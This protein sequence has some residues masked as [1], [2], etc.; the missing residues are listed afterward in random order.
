MA[1]LPAALARHPLH[2]HGTPC[3]RAAPPAIQSPS[4]Q[5]KPLP[6]FFRASL[7]EFSTSDLS[8]PPLSPHYQPTL[9]LNCHQASPS[10][11]L[12]LALITAP[13]YWSLTTQCIQQV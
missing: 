5:P 11:K 9:N 7:A 1:K 6:A 10:H 3:T 2:S 13:L 8:L 12:N 4:P